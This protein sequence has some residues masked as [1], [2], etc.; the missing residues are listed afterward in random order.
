MSIVTTCIV[1]FDTHWYCY[2]LYTLIYI[3]SNIYRILRFLE[4]EKPEYESRNPKS[5]RFSP[6]TCVQTAGDV[7]VVPESWGHGIINI[8]VG[9]VGVFIV[10]VSIVYTLCI[11][12]FLYVIV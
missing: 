4:I 2:I 6:T 3:P 9:T 11:I 12:R 5:E 1:L 10:Y 7:V 8:Q